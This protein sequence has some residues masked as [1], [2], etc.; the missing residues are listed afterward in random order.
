MVYTAI[1]ICAESRLSTQLVASYYLFLI[2]FL[3]KLPNFPHPFSPPPTFVQSPSLLIILTTRCISP[4]YSH[5]WRINRCWCGCWRVCTIGEWC[6]CWTPS[7]HTSEYRH[8]GRISCRRGEGETLN[9]YIVVLQCEQLGDG[10]YKVLCNNYNTALRHPRYFEKIRLISYFPHIYI[11]KKYSTTHNT[12]F[13]HLNFFFSLGIILFWRS[14]RTCGVNALLRTVRHAD[15]RLSK[16]HIPRRY[17]AS[18]S[19]PVL[20][21]CL[22]FDNAWYVL[23]QICMVSFSILYGIAIYRIVSMCTSL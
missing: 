18:I 4:G 1:L 19:F 20:L 6:T 3:S 8:G 9:S 2:Y 13:S 12:P 23:N 5:A 21:F 11:H 14:V 15:P 22:E 17:G 7:P 10:A 16:F